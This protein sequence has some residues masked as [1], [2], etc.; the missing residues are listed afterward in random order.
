VQGQPGITVPELAAKLG[1]E[2]NYLHRVLLDGKRATWRGPGAGVGEL[3]KHEVGPGT[4][5]VSP[6]GHTD[7]GLAQGSSS[8]LCDAAGAVS[9]EWLGE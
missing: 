4:N 7:Q 9:G 5:Q 1:I 8:S 2:Q 3:I 6:I